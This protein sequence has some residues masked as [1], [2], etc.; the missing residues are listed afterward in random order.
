LNNGVKKFDIIK[1]VSAALVIGAVFYLWFEN[2]P[3][4]KMAEIAVSGDFPGMRIVQ[5]SDGHGRLLPKRIVD[6][7]RSF[8]PDMIALT[9]DMIDKST[10]DAESVVLSIKSLSE[11]APTFFVPGNHERAN[12]KGESFIKLMEKSGINVL[13]NDAD[14]VILN[15]K[16][17]VIVCGVDDI[18]FNLDDIYKSV[19]TKERCDILLSHSPA[20]WKK[21]SDISIPLIL[22]GHTHGGQARIPFFGAVFLPDGN[23]PP[24]LIKGVS[25]RE[26]NTFHVSVGFG[27]SVIPLRIMNR[28]EINLITIV[29]K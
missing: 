13:L 22:A 16:D 17:T 15:G 14:E 28:A 27:T 24:D 23:I 12:P 21:I 26:E 25:V 9:G 20:I 29:S 8:S 18:N 11:I 7:I 19:S 3:A 4:I 1:A 10:V 5:I 2:I 6:S